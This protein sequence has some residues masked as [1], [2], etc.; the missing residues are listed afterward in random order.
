MSLWGFLWAVLQKWTHK[1]ATRS[2]IN[3]GGYGET[4]WSIWQ[5]KFGGRGE[6]TGPLL[7]LAPQID[8]VVGWPDHDRPGHDCVALTIAH[9]NE[10]L[11]LSEWQLPSNIP[12]IGIVDPCVGATS[13][14]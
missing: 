9:R 5:K 1:G 2:E 8:I 11:L 3:R 6:A 4:I 14:L 7:S 13:S 10:V 12:L